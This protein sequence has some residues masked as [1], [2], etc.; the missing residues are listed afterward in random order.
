MTGFFT[1]GSHRECA[2]KLEANKSVFNCR[3]DGDHGPWVMLS[4]GLATDMTMWDE[5]TAALKG[6]YR[7][8]RYD[9]RGHGESAAPAGDYTL[10]MLVADA[11]GILDAAGVEQTHFVGLS[12]GGMVGLGMLVN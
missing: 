11:V 10:D 1:L 5:L 9:A 12:M 8:L 4:H 3:V 2:L 6:R 7:I